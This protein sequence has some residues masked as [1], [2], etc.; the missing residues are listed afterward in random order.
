MLGLFSLRRAAASIALAALLSTSFA[1]SADALYDVKPS[2][3]PG[4]PGTLIRVWPLEGGGPSGVAFRILYRS[5]NVYGRPIAV[6]GA[7]YLPSGTPPPGGWPIIAWAHPTTGVMPDC[8]PSLMPDAAGMIWGLGSMLAAGYMVAA[9][10]YPGLGTAGI[11]PF[12]IGESEARA[13]LDSVRAARSLEDFNASERFVVWGHS[14]GGQAA[15]FTGQIAQSYAPELTLLGVA[16]AAPAT[17][18][19][20]LFD[21]DYHDRDG[22]ELAAMALLSWSRLNDIPLENVVA[23]QVVPAF[24]RTAEQCGESLHEFRK[25]NRDE[26]P[27]QKQFLE[28]NPTVT[29]PW[30]DIMTTNTPGQTPI[31]VPVFIAQGLADTTVE[32]AITERFTDTLC[33]HGVTVDLIELPGVDHVFAARDSV[34]KALAWMTDRFRG[35]P[36]PDSCGR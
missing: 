18:L 24:R 17:Y 28:I 13:V 26:Q 12:L 1:A 36:A 7:V 19:K 27:L 10:D 20:R 14:Q 15:L 4:P 22:K 33:S 21:D 25:L 35:L 31:P 32:P 34:D 5:T 3:I 30:D 6:S 9:T 16:A 23:P 2:D 8:A 29:P 11:H